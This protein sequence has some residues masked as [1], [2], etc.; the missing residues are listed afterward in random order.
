MDAIGDPS[1][2]E[3][4]FKKSAQV[5][6]T[7]ILLNILGYYMHQ[8]PAPLL[9]VQPTIEMA[10][11]FS[12][13]RL[14][15]MIRDSDVLHG[16]VSEQRISSATKVT[17]KLLHKVFPGGHIT[18]AGSNSPASLASRPVRIVL[19]DEVSRYPDSAGPEG[20]PVNLAKK[21]STTFWNRKTVL[22][23][24]PTIEGRCRIDAAW[25]ESDQR[26][27]FVPCPHCQHEQYLQWAGVT[28]PKDQPHRAAYACIE[29]GAL[30]TDEQRWSVLLKGYWKPTREHTGV[31]GF[32][33][34][35]IYSPWVR[36]SEMVSSFL[37]AQR[38]GPE[39]LKTW[40]NTSLG[41]CWSEKSGEK[42]E[43]EDLYRRREHYRSECPD[44]V[45]VLVAG[46]DVQD[47]RIECE[48]VGWSAEE[49]SYGIDYFRLY[50][51]PGQ[52]IL[53]EKL[54]E[55]LKK[56]YLRPNGVKMDIR[57]VGIDS[58]GH[59]T[60]EVYGWCKKVGRSWA[61]PLKGSSEAGKPVA[62]FPRKPN[63]RGIY[64]TMVGTDT[65]KELIY[66]RY[67]ILQPGPGYCHYP[68]SEMYDEVYFQQA[69]AEVK[70]KKY[71]HGREYFVWDAGHRRNEAS[72]CRVYALAAVRI[73]QQHFGV[74]LQR[75][76]DIAEERRQREKDRKSRPEPP[77][78]MRGSDFIGYE[79]DW[80]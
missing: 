56:S 10:L 46:V 60:D 6:A 50:G 71:R 42:I 25:Q 44:E 15:P 53:W 7:E 18:L 65:A 70:L 16:L 22:T 20:D 78:Q 12:K 1:I 32:H 67:R 5:G 29:C 59:Y 13:D 8:D 72:D 43:W 57:L 39:M 30:W 26:R 45:A 77:P 52:P 38:G 21:R 58:G 80:L 4:V 27:Y 35:E 40:I 55:K 64:L 28:W 34:S 62:V 76:E 73:L 48:V 3:V 79:G 9:L 61:I 37:V 23:S 17:S 47:D 63:K 68:V 74:V 14:T 54:T 24:T 49:E 75:P 69:T 2:S 31:A 66:G 36:L 19:C 51:D 11:A 33:L 41:E